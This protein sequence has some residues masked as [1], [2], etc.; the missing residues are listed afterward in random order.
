MASENEAATEGVAGDLSACYNPSTTCASMGPRLAYPA[1]SART[2][3]R[4][5]VWGVR[6]LVP[7]MLQQQDGSF[8]YHAKACE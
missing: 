5:A 6:G 1:N 2:R 4:I 8:K 3:G 7:P